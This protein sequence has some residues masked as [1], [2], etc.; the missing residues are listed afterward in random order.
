VAK[1]PVI[2]ILPDICDNELSQHKRLKDER[3]YSGSW[4]K[5]IVYHVRAVIAAGA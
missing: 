4:F 2:K 3:V 5:D 1:Y